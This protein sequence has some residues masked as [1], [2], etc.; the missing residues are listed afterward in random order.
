[1]VTVRL[2]GRILGTDSS[3]PIGNGF[4]CEGLGGHLT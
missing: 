4:Q 2:F 1:M 3:T